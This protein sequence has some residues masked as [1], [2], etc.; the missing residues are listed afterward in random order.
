MTHIL[1]IAPPCTA[2]NI[3]M[4]RNQV[5]FQVLDF[6]NLNNFS[7]I[8]L[9]FFMHNSSV[10]AEFSLR[11]PCC[12]SLQSTGGLSDYFFHWDKPPILALLRV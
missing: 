8:L 1:W 10:F 6:S 5:N 3:V 11:Q 2:D 4:E 9:G 12:S 7:D